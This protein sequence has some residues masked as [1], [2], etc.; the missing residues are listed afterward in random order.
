MEST[1][2]PV[3]RV[4]YAHVL[5][6]GLTGLLLIAAVE[7][8]GKM[9][10]AFPDPGA[11]YLLGTVYVAYRL[12]LLPGLI[13][14][15]LTL[16]H[17]CFYLAEP[18]PGLHYTPDHF[19]HLLMAA[20]VSPLAAILVGSLRSQLEETRNR[21]AQLALTDLLTGLY[22]R[23]AFI[24]ESKRELAR[25]RRMSASPGCMLALNVDEFKLVVEACGHQI[26][27]EVLM[28]VGQACKRL[29]RA[30][31]I[32]ARISGEEF[33]VLLP[34]STL[35]EAHACANRLREAVEQLS[36]S[37]QFMRVTICVGVTQLQDCSDEAFDVAQKQAMSALQMA[38]KAGR[39]KVHQI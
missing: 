23:G 4:L 3:S 20:V 27:E 9:L 35:E 17:L 24:A 33:M 26:G 34:E 1:F 31:D 10:A 5:R 36:F 2:R 15:L 39:N 32:M 13:F 37:R 22:N 30:S 16:A 28:S 6:A 29:L 8:S 38:M 21:L 25:R 11:M 19:Y 12:G 18:G 7:L 14:S